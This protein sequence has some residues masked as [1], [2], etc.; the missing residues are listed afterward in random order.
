MGQRRK[1]GSSDELWDV[2]L[3]GRRVAVLS[4]PR[5]LDMFWRSFAIAAVDGDRSIDDD[6]VWEQCRFEFRERATGNLAPHAFAGGGVPFVV[7]GRV[8][9]RGLYPGDVA[10]A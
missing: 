1:R 6:D 8:V 2:N 4:D 7:D 5:Q 10:E 9:M 3:D